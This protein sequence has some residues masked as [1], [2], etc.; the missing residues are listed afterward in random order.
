VDVFTIKTLLAVSRR[1]LTAM[2]G[3]GEM[4]HNLA[5]A[6]LAFHLFCHLS[7]SWMYRGRASMDLQHVRN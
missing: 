7:F 4:L 5:D 3:G 2:H 6:L 1:C